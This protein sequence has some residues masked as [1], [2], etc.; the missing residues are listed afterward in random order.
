[1][2]PLVLVATGRPTIFEGLVAALRRSQ[3]YEL[4]RLP[5]AAGAADAPV[6]RSASL[7]VLD[8]APTP[9]LAQR[10]RQELRERCPGR[11]SSPPGTRWRPA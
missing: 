10:L 7:V 5:I 2:R 6:V 11:G 1:M 9:L 4:E 8:M 3:R